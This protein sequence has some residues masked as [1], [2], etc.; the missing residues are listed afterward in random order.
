MS[1]SR[2]R[3][4]LC[5]HRNIFLS[6]RGGQI[7]KI[8]FVFWIERARAILPSREM[9]FPQQKAGLPRKENLREKRSP[10][11]LP[12]RRGARKGPGDPRV[13]PFREA[14]RS[15]NAEVARKGTL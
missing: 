1:R 7:E 5:V 12:L 10:K 8:R 15:A 3:F 14:A 9:N 4:L 13:L 2:K 6:A 11:V